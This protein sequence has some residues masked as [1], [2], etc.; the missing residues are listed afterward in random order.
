MCGILILSLV[1]ASVALSD[2]MLGQRLILALAYLAFVGI[3]PILTN[4][5][6]AFSSN[7][8]ILLQCLLNHFKDFRRRAQ[9]YRASVTP[10]DL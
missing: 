3:L 2:W 10:F 4:M 6:Q 8:P 1:L 9:A 7:R 5:S